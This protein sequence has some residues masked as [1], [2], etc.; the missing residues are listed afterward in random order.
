M[1]GGDSLM[2][3]GFKFRIY[4]T[5]EQ[6]KL[7]NKTFGCCRLVYNDALSRRSKAYSRRKESLSCTTLKNNL[8]SMKKRLSFLK[9][10]DS[11]ALQ[12]SIM[13]MDDAYHNF[14]KGSGFP[15][16]KSKKNNVQSYRTVSSTTRVVDRKHIELAKLG[17]VRCII[18]RRVLG[19][20][21]SATISRVAGKYFVSFLCEVPDEPKLPTN[22][23]QIGL[24]LGVKEFAVDSDGKVY[25]NPKY[26]NKSLQK[27]A[28]ESQKL[29]KL[30]KGSNNFRKQAMKVARLHH[31]IANKRMDYTQKLSTSLIK[32]YQVIC[33]EDLNI[34]SMLQTDKLNN[35]KMYNNQKHAHH[36]SIADAGWG[37]FVTLLS[38]KA[39]AAGRTLVKIG[40]F[41][42]SSQMCH[43]CGHI[44]PMIKDIN[45]RQWVCSECGESHD[46][47][48]NAALNILN[49]GLRILS[50]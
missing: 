44:N 13:M 39:D 50:L 48:H 42:P 46:R 4:P 6:I 37:Q 18:N 40:R 23:K 26:L 22:D 38:S 1:K 32:E 7:I 41:V 5:D 25:E 47:D 12:Q 9:E 24:D 11:T 45:V 14:F 29:S 28:F 15:K 20:I 19:T 43:H 27:L 35:S 3:K 33:V 16:Y 31:K 49:E 10:V 17:I 2:Y 36:R 8:P 34:K 21:K 30:R